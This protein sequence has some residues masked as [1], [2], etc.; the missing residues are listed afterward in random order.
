MKISSVS[1][2]VLASA[3]SAAMVVAFAPTAAF[4][5]D[6]G[7]NS[8]TVDN[9]AVAE[10]PAG[11][12]AV[13]TYK[14][15]STTYTEYF[16]PDADDP[17]DNAAKS[18]QE[19]MAYAGAFA[20]AK[21]I[22]ATDVT[23]DVKAYGTTTLDLNGHTLANLS[24]VTA[25]DYK[26]AAKSATNDTATITFG[27]DT[28]EVVKKS[29]K[30][31]A[32]GVCSKHDA[33]TYTGNY[34]LAGNG[35]DS[36]FRGNPS[37]EE[38]VLIDGV[39]YYKVENDDTITVG[40][41]LYIITEVA[42]VKAA[43]GVKLTVVDSSEGKTGVISGD[44][45]AYTTK[46]GVEYAAY[47][48]TAIN[49]TADVEIKGGTITSGNSSYA[50]NDVTT[51]AGE[52]VSKIQ[53]AVVKAETGYG[54]KNVDR[55]VDNGLYSPWAWA[56]HTM[57]DGATVKNAEVSAIAST[58]AKATENADAYAIG[59]DNA[60]AIE[61]SKIIATGADHARAVTKAATVKKSTIEATSTRAN[62]QAYAVF[63]ATGATSD[64]TISATAG[65]GAVATALETAAAVSSSTV[66]ATA[67]DAT[68]DKAGV[69]AAADAVAT[70]IKATTGTNTYK[71][72]VAT[73]KAGE[74][75]DANKAI[76]RAID[77][78]VATEI[79]VLSGSY[80]G[81]LY[82]GA[83]A[84][85]TKLLLQG[86]EYSDHAGT[87]ADEAHGYKGLCTKGKGMDYV[88]KTVAPT[89]SVTG[90]KLD[91]IAKGWTKVVAGADGSGLV[92]DVTKTYYYESTGTTTPTA[93]TD[94]PEY[95]F[96]TA[97][98]FETDVADSKVYLSNSA[99]SVDQQVWGVAGLSAAAGTAATNALEAII[100]DTNTYGVGYTLGGMTAAE[101]K[102]AAIDAETS[103]G[104]A[105]AADVW[106]GDEAMK[107]G[108][109]A[110]DEEKAAIEAFNK[111]LQATADAAKAENKVSY[112]YMTVDL[113]L[114]YTAPKAPAGTKAT[115]VAAITDL[116]KRVK[117]AGD[118]D[119]HTGDQG[120]AVL[121]DNT[122]TVLPTNFSYLVFGNATDGLITATKSTASLNTFD[123]K[124]FTAMEAVGE[125]TKAF[126][127]VKLADA[128]TVLATNGES[129]TDK[130]DEVVTEKATQSI[131]VA[132]KSRTLTLKKGVK[133]TAKS[134]YFKMGATAETAVATAKKSGSS[135]ITVSG[136]KVTLKKGTKKGTYTAKVSLKAAASDS[137][138][139]AAKTIT[140]KF[141]V[142]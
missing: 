75:T 133:K 70:A 72:V 58:A 89:I 108:A 60:V 105:A 22:L 124:A 59:G 34:V 76:A 127:T 81:D 110:T 111:G 13:V 97:A 101:V 118:A 91:N 20:N 41:T 125:K 71:K 44:A 86:G 104:F 129:A 47:S 139:A 32:V 30:A 113:D 48:A 131:E 93:S 51:I 16:G 85:T 83:T 38:N 135:R 130:G 4:G 126:K 66:T 65:N 122:I 117:A 98:Q 45:A 109:L 19:A 33:N 73:A 121:E 31:T 8:T 40:A 80:T 9:G 79:T 68:E 141:V 84:V 78:E 142:K 3:L 50:D 46:A 57:K 82:T 140:V 123:G 27:T 53:D 39:Q 136:Q 52:N 120:A 17:N 114:T 128:F 100:T 77:A 87:Y 88:Y 12:V 36:A 23:A 95:T 54:Y 119:K 99:V 29:Y 132:K 7:G 116:G 69:S 15:G 14:D 37:G 61:S 35:S 28:P 43:A 137:Y 5:A 49:A 115:E 107:A 63:N 10:A 11:T 112:G 103:G 96:T 106:Y 90:D 56:V 1:K 2:K 26:T 42:A 55:A 138:L 62:G 134:R 21:V 6:L 18:L 94:L 92:Y 74:K 64:S 24:N 102:A 25:D 67:G